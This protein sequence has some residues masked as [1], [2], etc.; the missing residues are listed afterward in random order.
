VED[1]LK[2]QQDGWRSGRD[3]NAP[4]LPPRPNTVKG[5]TRQPLCADNVLSCVWLFSGLGPQFS[6]MRVSDSEVEI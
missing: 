5:A 3:S 1:H 2:R 6:F 4:C